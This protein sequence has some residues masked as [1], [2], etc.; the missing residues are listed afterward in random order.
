MIAE[1]LINMATLPLTSFQCIKN[2]V[3][4]LPP[5]SEAIFC[6]ELQNLESIY[7]QLYPNHTVA[8]L[9]PFYQ[10]CGRVTLAG[11]LFG[12]TRNAASATSSSV[13]MAH[14]PGRGDDL[15]TIDYTRMRV[16][17]VQYYFKHHAV[18]VV[19]CHHQRKT[20]NLYSLV[21]FGN[22]SI[23]NKTCLGAL[24]QSALICLS[25]SQH[26]LSFQC[27]GFLKNVDL[28]LLLLK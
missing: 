4:L 19:R 6:T 1:K 18:Q 8:Y 17:I 3:E 11:D 23:H 21:S 15:S 20:L 27:S 12:S 13:V 28:V 25:L 22:K 2:V 9:S 26:V 7:K 5:L 10:C 24:R 14:W 16:G